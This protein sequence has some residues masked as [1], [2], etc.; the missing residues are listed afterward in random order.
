MSRPSVE[1]ERREQILRAVCEVVSEKGYKSLRVADVAKRAKISSGSVHYYFETKDDLLQAAFEW[2]FAHSLERRAS[3]LGSGA[4]AL[5]RLRL[6]VDSFLPNEKET[7]ASWHVWAELWVAALHDPVLRELNERVYGEWRAMIVEI[8][9]IGQAEGVIVE[10][11]PV[12]L[13][14]ALISTID[15]LAI[16]VLLRSKHVTSGRVRETCGYLIDGMTVEVKG[17]NSA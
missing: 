4:N 8:I 1:A 2:N 3:I 13:A 11:D 6:Y 5:D 10:G 15:G 14:N 16:Q 7:T 9:R 12:L 17:L